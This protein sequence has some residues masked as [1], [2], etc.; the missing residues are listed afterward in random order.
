[1]KYKPLSHQENRM[2]FE[3]DTNRARNNF[4]TNVSNNLYFLLKNRFEWMNF[5]IKKNDIGIEVG[6]GTGVSK[7]FIKSENFKITD[8][9]NN[10]WLDIKMIDALDTKIESGSLDY[11]VSSN[12]IHHVPYPILFFEEMHRILK[13]GGKLIIQE[14]NCS[15]TM[16]FLLRLMR[17]EGYDFTINVFDREL[18]C[19]DP[20]NL[21]SANCA[22]PNL[23]FDN[24]ENFKKN[25][26]NF[27]VTYTGFSEFFLFINSGGVISKTKYLP[28]PIVGLKILKLIDNFLCKISPSFFALQRQVVLKKLN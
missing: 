13:H 28:M 24:L 7:E 4:Y 14:I 3:G 26:P 20:Q 8:Y 19:T 27:K 10:H 9:A 5:F 17:H 16:R 1:M 21:W 15:S 18:I 2:N 6:A 12:M 11:V 25:I 23:L 22:I